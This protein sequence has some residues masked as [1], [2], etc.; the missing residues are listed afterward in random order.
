LEEWVGDNKKS[1]K[2]IIMKPPDKAQKELCRIK[3]TVKALIK[4]NPDGM[5]YSD[6]YR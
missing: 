2:N 1:L 4:Q 5:T 6:I 3:K